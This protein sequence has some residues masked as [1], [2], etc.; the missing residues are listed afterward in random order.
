MR[1]LFLSIYAFFYN[2]FASPKAKEK[3]VLAQGSKRLVKVLV[4]KE[5]RKK[6]MIAWL[7]KATNNGYRFNTQH[8][9]QLLLKK[10][11]DEMRERNIQI[12]VT[13]NKISL[14]NARA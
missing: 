5:T 10:F 4:E 3:R 6:E 8:K 13:G 14:T 1:K 2:L 12:E 11:G 9:V 7:K